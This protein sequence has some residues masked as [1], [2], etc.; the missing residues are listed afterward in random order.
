MA[1]GTYLIV[2]TALAEA[3]GSALVLRCGPEGRN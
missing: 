3:R 1:F 2:D